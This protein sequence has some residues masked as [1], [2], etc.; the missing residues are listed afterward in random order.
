[1]SLVLKNVDPWSIYFG[2]P[3]KRIKERKRDLIQLEKTLREE[4]GQGKEIF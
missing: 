1:M 4:L 2:I 3:A